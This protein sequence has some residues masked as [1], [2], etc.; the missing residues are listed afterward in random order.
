MIQHRLQIDERSR[1]RSA[2]HDAVIVNDLQIYPAVGVDRPKGEVGCQRRQRVNLLDA[3]VAE[4]RH[5][6][7]AETVGT[8][9]AAE[10]E[11]RPIHETPQQLGQTAQT[12]QLAK[13]RNSVEILF[14]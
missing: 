8:L 1:Y 3:K 12:Q 11:S 2:V 14:A 5:H 7:G 6:E 4:A 9:V 10:I 13:R